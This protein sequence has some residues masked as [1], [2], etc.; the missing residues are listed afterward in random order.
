M[1]HA[2]AA[3]PRRFERKDFEFFPSDYW[4]SPT[5]D[6]AKNGGIDVDTLHVQVGRAL[7][8]WEYV[9]GVIADLYVKTCEI[10]DGRASL[11]I[12]KTFGS[13]EASGARLSATIMMLRSYLSQ[14][15]HLK[16][17]GWIIG[18]FRS[19]VSAAAQR[20]NEIAHGEAI[21]VDQSLTPS[22]PISGTYLVSP[23]YMTGRNTNLPGTTHT[24]GDPIPFITSVYAY[25]PE[26]IH[27]MTEKFHDLR[28]K[29]ISLTNELTKD[30]SGVPRIIQPVLLRHQELSLAQER[31]GKHR[32]KP[33]PG[34]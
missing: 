2:K 22:A 16:E 5:K 29:I 3:S 31:Q 25:T 24:A 11:I 13:M 17:C 14:Y 30:P 28:H 9:E 32:R 12:A 7:T 10:E 18:E 23:A 21:F 34:P 26:D 27:R 1:S 33:P 8:A 6:V 4:T 20:R 15:I 19:A